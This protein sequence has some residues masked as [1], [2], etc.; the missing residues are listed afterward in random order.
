MKVLAASFPGESLSS[1]LAD[2]YLLTV[3]SHSLLLVQTSEESRRS[4]F[5]SLEGSQP[6]NLNLPKPQPPH[7]ITLGVR[8]PTNEFWEGAYTQSI[9]AVDHI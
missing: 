8:A 9:I 1:C 5:L 3:S 6:P 2:G 7:T 4:I